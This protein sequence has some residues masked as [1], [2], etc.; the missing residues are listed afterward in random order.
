MSAEAAANSPAGRRGQSYGQ[1]GQ[2]PGWWP[3]VYDLLERHLALAPPAG[4]LVELGARLER[5]LVD[6]VA[7]EALASLKGSGKAARAAKIA[8][9][10]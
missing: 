6:P 1:V 10:Q 7:R 8:L 3:Q 5:S 2:W 9:S 4:E